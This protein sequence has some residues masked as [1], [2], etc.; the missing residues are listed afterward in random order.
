MVSK[1]L[2]VIN[3]PKGA[4]RECAALAL[5][6]YNGC[7]HRCIYC[8][9]NGRYSKN[10]EY[11]KSSRPRLGISVQIANDAW[12]LFEVYGD[13]CPEALISFIGDAYQPAE[14]SLGHARLAIRILI[15]HKIPFTILTKSYLVKRDFDLLAP[16]RYRLLNETIPFTV[17]RIMNESP[18]SFTLFI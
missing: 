16:Y 10:G 7:T 11:F 8:Y 5:N 2:E 1:R 15:D 13:A 12:F 14:K 3:E 6:L 4:A 17:N 9:N 18:T